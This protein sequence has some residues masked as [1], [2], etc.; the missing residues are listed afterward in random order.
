MTIQ[1]NK[2][3]VWDYW[4]GMNYGIDTPLFTQT[5]H[6]NVIWHG[7]EPL[8]RL[9]GAAAVHEQFWAP[10]LNAIPDLTRRPYHFIGGEFEGHDWVCG[11]GDLI[12]TFASAWFGIPA[13]GQSVRFRFGE[14]CKIEDGQITEIRLIVDLIH[15]IR[16]AGINLVPPNYGR[17]IW[18]PGPLAG[19]G[20]FFDVQN[21][22]ESTK[23][24]ELVEEMIFGG[25]NKYNKDEG[26]ASQGLE[27]FWH[28]HMV[29]HG[30]AGIG[31]AYGMDEFKQNAQGPIVSAFPDRKGPGHQ[32]RIAEGVFAASTGWPSLVGTHINPYMDWAPT[33]ERI[34]WNIMDFWKRDG[35]KLAENWVM[36]DLIGAAKSSGVNLWERL[37]Q[38]TGTQAN[39]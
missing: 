9:E 21:P 36:I 5:V 27:K 12:G 32:A 10:L 13:S 28:P 30:P 20:V 4:Q 15:L 34:G 17:D 23:T 25:L 35:D 11:T 37:H 19:D 2:K 22:A 26:Q 8:R 38:A 14:F 3:L 16:Q 18:I 1:D 31:S 24:R 7:F 39:G 29:W 33:G 6:K